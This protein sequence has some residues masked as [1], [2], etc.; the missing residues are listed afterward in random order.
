LAKE[1]GLGN[2]KAEAIGFRGFPE[3]L[4]KPPTV[5]TLLM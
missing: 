4:D 5:Y 2:G 3:K 1:I